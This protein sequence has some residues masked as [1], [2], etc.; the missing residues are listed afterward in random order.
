MSTC[1]TNEKQNGHSNKLEVTL[2]RSKRILRPSDTRDEKVRVRSNTSCEQGTNEKALKQT[3]RKHTESKSIDTIDM[4]TNCDT[5]FRLISWKSTNEITAR[6][7]TKIIQKWCAVKPKFHLARHVMSRLDTT[8]HVRRVEHKHFGCV[9]LVKQHG[10]TRSSRRARH[11]KGVASRRDAPSGIWAL[12][13]KRFT[14]RHLN[15]NR[16]YPTWVP[17]TL[18]NSIKQIKHWWRRH[19]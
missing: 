2:S 14:T 7:H 8:R 12:S 6:S 17:S 19:I 1:I 13:K 11:V 5:Q 15:Y 9:E 3:V 4:R 18:R 10:S 16:Y